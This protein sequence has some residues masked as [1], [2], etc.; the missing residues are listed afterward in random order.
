[1]K[2]NNVEISVFGIPIE[3]INKTRFVLIDFKNNETLTFQTEDITVMERAI[4][5]NP[6]FRIATEEDWNR[7]IKNNL[8]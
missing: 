6:D 8:Y 3:E 2:D 5:D 7:L 4:K 1:M